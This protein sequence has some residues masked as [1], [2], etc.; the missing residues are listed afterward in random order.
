MN[1][2]HGSQPAPQRA[3]G[4]SFPG[5]WKAA[6]TTAR[7]RG[8]WTTAALC[9]H[10]SSLG[11]GCSEAGGAGKGGQAQSPLSSPW[12]RKHWAPRRLSCLWDGCELRQRSQSPGGKC[13]RFHGP[14]TALSSRPEGA[15]FLRWR[16]EGPGE[17]GGPTVWT[18][19][20]CTGLGSGVV[21]PATS[22]GVWVKFSIPGS[23]Q[24]TLSQCLLPPCAPRP[25]PA[26]P[27]THPP[28]T[29]PIPSCPALQPCAG[30]DVY[31]WKLVPG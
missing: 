18:P 20:P 5:P 6:E 1:L 25:S 11:P 21:P 19:I 27:H 4:F 22:P 7:D 29:P 3:T 12:A 10:H 16:I 23:H 30:A 9:A 14:A 17:A 28:P 31:F 26:P 15:S 8:A 24:L 2:A 13:M